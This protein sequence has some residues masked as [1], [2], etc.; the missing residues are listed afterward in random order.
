MT[1]IVLEID[2]KQ[3][4]DLGGRFA[5]ANAT[6][7][8]SQRE[9]ARFLGEKW[10]EFAQAE[11]PKDTGEFAQGIYYRTFEQG[12]GIGLRGYFSPREGKENLG[13]WIIEGTRPH[14]IAATNAEALY[15]FWKKIGM[16]TIV[17]KKATG[18]NHV[19]KQGRFWIGKGYVNHPGTKPNDFN[20]RAFDQLYSE[21]EPALNRIARKWIVTLQGGTN[22]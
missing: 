6:L 8:E 17:P 21:F 5:T 13:V 9:E 15:F 3:L 20:R 18:G 10:V 14:Q 2:F 1:S 16:W 12:E 11:A 19:D 4:R 22:D 7:M